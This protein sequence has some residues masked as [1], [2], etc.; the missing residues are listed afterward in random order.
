M[1]F[2]SGRHW[3]PQNLEKDVREKY[4]KQCQNWENRS[5]AIEPETEYILIMHTLSWKWSTKLSLAVTFGCGFGNMQCGIG[6][7]IR[8]YELYSEHVTSVIGG[9]IWLFCFFQDTRFRLCRSSDT[10]TRRINLLTQC[11]ESL[12]MMPSQDIWTR[13]NYC[14]FANYLR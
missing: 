1:D 14:R 12:L 7:D 3:V 6:S 13:V 11:N 8:I 10:V 4:G 9:C 5:H 2:Q